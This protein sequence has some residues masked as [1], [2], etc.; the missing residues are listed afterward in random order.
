VLGLFIGNNI[1][2]LAVVSGLAALVLASPAIRTVL[3]I[4]STAYLLYLALRIAFAGSRVAFI[5]A[6]GEPGVMAGILLQPINP[7]AYAVNTA[8]FTGFAIYPDAFAAEVA[9]KLLIMNV[10]W[11]PI[12]VAWVWFG[13]LLK[14]LDL[15]ERRQ[16]LINIIMAASMLLVVALAAASAM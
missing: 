3:F 10:I 11:V 2:V 1:V 6:Q 16:R 8:L 15:P 4:L 13:Y 5:E 14:R 12:H 9:W 7:K